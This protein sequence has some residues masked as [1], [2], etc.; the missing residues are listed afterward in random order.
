[1]KKVLCLIDALRLGGAERQLIG[2]TAFLREKGYDTDLA[3]YHQHN[4]YED[5]L[6]RHHITPLMIP[7]RNNPLSKLYGIGRFIK[8][9]HYDTVI[10][11]IDGPTK[12]CCLLKMF[13]AKFQLIVSERNTS[14]NLSKSLKIK[15]FLYRFANFIVPNSDSQKEFIHQHFP[16]LRDKT[17]TI[18][19]FTDTDHFTPEESSEASSEKTSFSILIPARIAR[20]K[21]V[22][23]LLLAIRDIQSQ[24]TDIHF[25]WVGNVQAGEEKYQELVIKTVQDLHLSDN[26]DF[27]PATKNIVE[28]YHK[29]D[30]VCLPS[31]FE[32]YPNTLCEAMSCAKPVICSNVCDNPKIVTD[33]INGFLFNPESVEDITATI[34]KICSLTD[35]ERQT[36][37]LANRAFAVQ[38][39]SKDRFVNKYIKLFE[40]N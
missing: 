35:K 27:V 30:I 5:L 11:Y 40:K 3:M 37:G 39:F 10:A 15:F 9:R 14:L 38:N 32:G 6:S 26:I 36:I 4:F 21:N 23:N 31:L 7:T 16:H 28:E 33:G 12:I 34:L 8:T 22:L 25:K 13:G 20:Q 29:C 18:H 19:N 17:V 2:L 1:M 24:T